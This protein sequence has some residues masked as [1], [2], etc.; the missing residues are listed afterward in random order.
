MSYFIP[1]FIQKRIL[2]YALSRLELL[3]TDALGMDNLDISWGKR[4]TIELKDVGIRIKKLSALLQLP[5]NLS[6]YQATIRLLRLTLPSDLHRSGIL[7]EADGITVKL[8]AES[9]ASQTRQKPKEEYRKAEQG[10]DMKASK[11]DRLRSSQY[12]VHDPG[13]T[14]LQARFEDNGD[15]DN[16]IFNHLPT[17]NDLAQSFLQTEPEEEKEELQ[18]ALLQ[19]QHMDQSRRSE[20]GLEGANDIGLGGGDLS[21]PAFLADFLRGVVDR[22]RVRVKDLEWDLELQLDSLPRKNSE[23]PGKEDVVAFRIVIKEIEFG[24]SQQITSTES[25]GLSE[26]EVQDSQGRFWVRLKEIQMMVVSDASL[27]SKVAI[28]PIP[29]PPGTTH[30]ST[31]ITVGSNPSASPGFVRPDSAASDPLKPTSQ[32]GISISDYAMPA[33]LNEGGRSIDAGD[34]KLLSPFI[35]NSH[36]LNKPGHE[37]PSLGVTLSKSD[38]ELSWKQSRQSHLDLHPPKEAVAKIRQPQELSLSQQKS[39]YDPLQA[40]KPPYSPPFPVNE[41]SL[42][43]VSEHSPYSERMPEKQ[44]RALKPSLEK[45]DSPF[46][47]DLSESRLFS[48]EESM[49]LSAMSKVS[50]DVKEN[51]APL[52]GGWHSNY[53]NDDDMHS[54]AHIPQRQASEQSRTATPLQ[55]HLRPNLEDAAHLID[56]DILANERLATPGPPLSRRSTSFGS[57]EKRVENV[58]GSSSLSPDNTSSETSESLE[59]SVLLAKKIATIDAIT[60]IVPS[61]ISAL[62]QKTTT[63]SSAKPVTISSEEAS[64]PDARPSEDQEAAQAITVKVGKIHIV[65][66]MTLT[67]MMVLA[68]PHTLSKLYD[69]DFPGNEDPRS[70]NIKRQVFSFDARVQQVSW[71]FLD[72]VR[73]YDV[74]GNLSPSSGAENVSSARDSEVL[75]RAEI[76]RLHVTHAEQNLSLTTKVTV[77]KFRLGYASSDII[78]FDP[79]LKMRDSTRDMFSPVDGDMMFTLRSSKNLLNIDV[80]TLPIRISLD[81]RKLDETFSWFG[82]LSSMLE[83]GNSMISTVTLKDAHLPSAPARSRRG[84]HFETIKDPAPAANMPDSKP[85]KLTARIG[86]LVFE[87]QGHLAILHVKSTAL[88]LV[89]RAEGVGLQI[90]RLKLKGPCTESTDGQIP[91]LIKLSNIRLEYLSTPKE[92]DLARLI[93]LVFPSQ[94]KEEDKF[95]DGLMVDTMLRQRRHGGVVRLTVDELHGSIINFKEVQPVL[96]VIED[97]KKL[98]TVTKYLPEDDRPGLLF[99]MLIKSFKS[100]FHVYGEFGIANLS[101]QNVEAAYVTFPTL[102]AVGVKKLEL[103]RNSNESLLGT[104]LSLNAEF[105]THLPLLLARYIGNEL[106]P[107]IRI[108]V[109]D[110]RVEYHVSAIMAFMGLKEDISS[111]ELLYD[112]VSS[113]ATLTAR[114]ISELDNNKTSSPDPGFTPSTEAPGFDM[115]MKDTVIGLNPRDSSSKCYIVLDEAFVASSSINDTKT[116]TLLDIKKASALIIDDQKRAMING[117]PNSD[118]DYIEILTAAGFVSVGTLMALKVDLQ[119]LNIGDA[120][121]NCIDS[122]I[123]GGLLLLETC[124]DSTQTLQQIICG[125]SP[126]MPKTTQLKY[127]TQAVPIEDMLASLTGDAYTT[128][129]ESY[130]NDEEEPLGSDEGDLVDDEV[131]QNLEFVSSF[132]DP[133]PAETSRMVTDSMLEEDLESVISR[134]MTREI[135]EKN[136]L[137]SFEEQA[138]VAPGSEPLDFREDHF[139]FGSSVQDASNGRFKVQNISRESRGLRSRSYPLKVNIQDFHVIWNLYDGYDWQNIRETISRAVA[140]VQAKANQRSSRE[141][142]RKSLN[143]QEQDED[144]IGD[145]LFN[146]IYIGIPANSDPAELARQV[147]HD[148]DDLASETGS[149]ATTNTS[150]SPNRQGY[151]SRPKGKKLRL[152]RSKYHKMTFELKGVSADLIVYPPGSGETESSVD[153]RIQDL[154]V[155]D[156]VPTSTWKKFATYMQDAGEREIDTSMVRLQLRNVKPVPDLAASEIMLKVRL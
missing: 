131:P 141:E 49:Y 148:L 120:T 39:Y 30:A 121:G 38:P 74:V 42:P 117:K 89:S 27:F 77:G 41:L 125:L 123:N 18:A 29:S 136:V 75:L 23:P 17:T 47:E 85:N 119:F 62:N 48:H 1:S 113:V 80:T 25:Q 138:R 13:G 99:L 5:Q 12:K 64:K 103:D 145:F 110:L 3:D 144:V 26:L 92:V 134:S 57:L 32:Q 147:N 44:D 152:K 90:D 63:S 139:D 102:A 46:L 66:D 135:G 71:Q 128:S 133:D 21:L 58:K 151:P 73:G 137:E 43:Y 76:E 59:H 142:K 20:Q 61:E 100:Q 33:S 88:K 55:D 84:V 72:A 45:L 150:N 94:L 19:S 130:L 2:R 81:L 114:Q 69:P 108:R 7:V 52:P 67:K 98:S 37:S 78:S 155:F 116:K 112:M 91:T 122:K 70:Q 15:S 124:A 10:R 4:S 101:S 68:V 109:H 83:L 82:G 35:D 86:G 140:E 96:S 149:Y 51:E 79:G 87:L 95:K 50:P 132:Y 153:I 93:E 60:I 16:D 54:S 65:G 28:S 8:R 129:E 97:L 40:H 105:D 6:I 111:E 24:S 118:G 106:E 126:P 22:I 143:M 34:S 154:D 56:P 127:R 31:V 107:T 11:A 36:V 104:S 9:A 156:H 115:V 53:S 14:K 146:S